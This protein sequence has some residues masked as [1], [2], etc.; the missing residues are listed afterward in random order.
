MNMEEKIIL[1]I[2]RAFAGS[3]AAEKTEEAKEALCADLLEKYRGLIEKGFS[4]EAAYQATISGIGDIFELVDSVTG[5]NREKALPSSSKILPA[6]ESFQKWGPAAV[7]GIFFLLWL[8]RFYLAPGLLFASGLPTF[9]LGAV[10]GAL[11]MRAFLHRNRLSFA[12]L[13]PK[14]QRPYQL[15][16]GGCGLL[17]LAALFSR[18]LNPAL[19]L[20]PAGAVALHQVIS[21][22][23]AFSASRKEEDFHE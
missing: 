14:E 7:C 23:T 3:P 4:P 2:N 10:L 15:V 6:A 20:I 11:G 18:R 13:L 19:W 21:A 5:E 8:I 22:W 12:P 16:W 17:F 1:Y 9:L